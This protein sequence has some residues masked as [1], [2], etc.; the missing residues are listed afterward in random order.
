V[1]KTF[2]L[3]LENRFVAAETTSDVN[4]NLENAVR[5]LREEGTGFV[6]CGVRAENQKFFEETLGLMKQRQENPPDT[7]SGKRALSRE[8]NKR[9]QREL[10]CSNTLFIE[11]AI[12]QNRGSKVFVQSLGRNH[13]TKLTTASGVVVALKPEVLSEVEDFYMRLY[14]SHA[15]RPDPENEHAR[16]TLF[17]H[18]TEQLQKSVLAK[19]RLLLDSLKREKPLGRT[20]LQQSC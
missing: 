6:T 5:V 2:Q 4:Q 9:V 10:R 17:R 8:I 12:E 7:S 11:R 15:S 13:L 19:S 16:A 20:A 1:S 3:N 18:F 14:V